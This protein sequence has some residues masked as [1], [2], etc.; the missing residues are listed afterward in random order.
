MKI[1]IN[2]GEN[3]YKLSLNISRIIYFDQDT[4]D[5]DIAPTILEF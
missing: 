4:S 1:N 3:N 2:D 5:F